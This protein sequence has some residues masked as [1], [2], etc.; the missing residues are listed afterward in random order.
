MADAGKKHILFVDDESNVL[1]GL[2]RMLRDRRKEWELEFVESA[3]LG[4]KALRKFPF[5]VVVSDMRMPGMDG[6]R[7][8]SEVRKLYPA[9]A[10]LVLSGH[11]DDEMLIRAAGGAHQY[12]SKPCDANHLQ[13]AISRTLAVREALKSPELQSFATGLSTVPSLPH[14]VTKI[15]AILDESNAD[16]GRVGDIIS[17]DLGMTAKILQLVNSDFFGFGREISNP[18]E[19]VQLLGP[20]TLRSLVA[21][22]GVFEQVDY[23]R[24]I[25]DYLL[26]MSNHAL[27]VAALARQICYAETRD[28]ALAGEAFTAGVLHD[29]GKVLFLINHEDYSELLN[30]QGVLGSRPNLCMLESETLGVTHAHLG[31]Y[32]L[33]LWGLPDRIIEA[34]LLH[35][36]PSQSEGPEFSPLAAVH[37][38]DYVLHRLSRSSDS[39]SY[40]VLDLG[41]LNSIGCEAKFDDWLVLGDVSKTEGIVEKILPTIS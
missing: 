26:A 36:Q 30:T 32:L 8:L 3:E 27:H 21:A 19:A 17:S 22:I 11:S 40:P 33:G 29:V 25:G 20:D 37:A 34:V 15:S 41:F 6:A 23:A 5:D 7:F 31:A 38:A 39:I 10:R 4:L 16:I 14:L 12:V 2:R 1:N 18:R 24:P 13:N 28:R 35:H 9:T